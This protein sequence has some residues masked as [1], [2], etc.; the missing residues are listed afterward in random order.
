MQVAYAPDEIRHQ[1]QQGGR[2]RQIP[3]E[4][5]HDRTGRQ[6]LF[7]SGK[8]PLLTHNLTLSGRRIYCDKIKVGSRGYRD[9]VVQRS[10]VPPR[11]L[12]WAETSYTNNPSLSPLVQFPFA[13]GLALLPQNFSLREPNT[14]PAL[15]R[16]VC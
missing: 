3:Q 12:V 7:L 11:I 8:L 1:F 6:R 4:Q 2:A 5:T 14:P 15:R 16:R 10:A 9:G 13:D